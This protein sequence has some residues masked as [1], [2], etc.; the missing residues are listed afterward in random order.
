MSWRFSSLCTCASFFVLVL[1]DEYVSN[2]G[3]FHLKPCTV[4][5][6]PVVFPMV[7]DYSILLSQCLRLFHC[8]DLCKVC[9]NGTCQ[10][11]SSAMCPTILL[12]IFWYFNL[13]FDNIIAYQHSK[14]GFYMGIYCG[15]TVTQSLKIRNILSILLCQ[16]LLCYYNYVGTIN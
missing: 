5:F 11:H 16:L 2:M 12:L 1:I 7:P 9:Y 10:D 4:S 15:R 14:H 8:F 3:E 13:H 6:L